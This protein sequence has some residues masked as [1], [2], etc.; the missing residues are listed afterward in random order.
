MIRR[1]ISGKGY[2]SLWPVAHYQ[3][4]NMYYPAVAS[5]ETGTAIIVVYSAKTFTSTGDVM[6][7]VWGSTKEGTGDWAAPRIIGLSSLKLSVP[8]VAM[9]GEANS[10]VV[11]EEEIATSTGNRWLVRATRHSPG[12]WIFKQFPVCSDCSSPSMAVDKAGNAWVVWVAD[13]Q[14]QSKRGATVPAQ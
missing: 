4:K 1:Y 7:T 5:N 2:D 6:N 10:T 11:W 3:G 13:G 8:Q 14:V 12:P 9:D